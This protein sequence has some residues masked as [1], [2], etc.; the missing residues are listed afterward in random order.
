MIDGDDCG[1]ISGMDEWQRKMKNSEKTC[2]SVALSISV[3][4]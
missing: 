4:T 1:A 2:F 3:L